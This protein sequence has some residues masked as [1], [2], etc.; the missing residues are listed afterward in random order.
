MDNPL[1][2]SNPLTLEVKAAYADAM[3]GAE[4][5][6]A[7]DQIPMIQSGVAGLGSRDVRTGDF[8]AVVRNSVANGRS[9][10]FFSLGIDH[11]T[12]LEREEDPD[13]RPA[14]EYAMRGHSIGGYGSV[15]TNKVI[16]TLLANLGLQVQAYPKYGSEKKGLPTTYYLTAASEH[17]R[18]HSE[19]ERVHFVPVNDI[20]AFNTSNP[21]AGVTDGGMVFIQSNQTEASE[22]W[23]RVPPWAKKMIRTRDI[24]VLALNAVRIAREEAP[25]PDL[26]QRFQGIVLLGIFLR[27][28]PF[29]A[30]LDLS[31]EALF[32]K[33][34][35]AVRKYWGKKGDD[36][37][38]SNLKAIRRGYDEVF[39]IDRDLVESTI[40]EETDE[41]PAGMVSVG[42]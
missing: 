17:I 12:A 34:E 31:D 41:L 18:T 36:V 8:T 1:A 7:I 16:A 27:H 5:Y 40:D 28:T 6:P 14:G 33:V 19:L 29:Q 35:E 9:R 39:E 38:E 13:L 2:Q 20:N 21:L 4:G 3:L 10:A 42:C 25:I 24:K 11:E 32:V 37:V 15:T 23:Q 22:V 30:D 26:E